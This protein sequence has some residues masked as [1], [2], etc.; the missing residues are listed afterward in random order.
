M[1]MGDPIYVA[2]IVISLNVTV[3]DT[4]I[5]QHTL[6]SYSN[7]LFSATDFLLMQRSLLQHRRELTSNRRARKLPV[8]VLSPKRISTVTEGKRM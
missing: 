5:Q 7:S 4:H 8:P 2:N 1:T 6:C 3:N